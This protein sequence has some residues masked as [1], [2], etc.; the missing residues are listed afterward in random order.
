MSQRAESTQRFLAEVGSELA[1]CPQVL[2]EFSIRLR[3]QSIEQSGRLT[4]WL[5]GNTPAD[6]A[7]MNRLLTGLAAPVQVQRAQLNAEGPLRQGISIAVEPEG[8]E[9]RLYLHGRQADT[10]AD[11]YE[12]WRWR[13]GSDPLRTQYS[14]HY[15]PE[16]ATG[17]RPQ[18]LCIA[19][20]RAPLSTLLAEE[21][22]QQCSGFWL[23][24]DPNGQLEKLDLAF[25]WSPPAESL[26]GLHM[27]AAS[28]AIPMDERWR[29]VPVRHVSFPIGNSPPSV[30]L[31]ASAPHSGAWPQTESALQE[32]VCGSA[33]VSNRAIEQQLFGKLPDPATTPPQVQRNDHFYDGE[34]ATWRQIL[35]PELHYHFGIFDDPAQP[36]DSS[37]MD[38][39]LRRA[40]IELYPFLPAGQRIY[41]VGCGWGGPLAMWSRDLRCPS[42]GI[43]NSRTQFRYAAARGL[44]VRWG[45]A[46]QTLPPGRFACAVLLESLS[47]IRNKERLL[48]VLRLFS[49]RLVMRVNCQDAAPPGSA[50]GGSMQM[51]S[52]T[53]LRQ[54]L[55]ASGWR[56]RHFVDRRLETLPSIAVWQRQVEQ[57][58]IER[59][60]QDPHLAALRTWTARV[61]RFPMEWARNNPLIEVMAD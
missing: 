45:D 48:R 30:T 28:L 9:L 34:I 31:Y 47:H 32:R 40:V 60:L 42:L 26:L 23:R 20:L 37:Q 13:T 14:F 16:T 18:E 24:E 8:I 5:C 2:L 59:D 54:L 36:A 22:L 38:E 10:G 44:P 3:P 49:D 46:E 12:A 21:R 1:T 58:P 19:A 56:V 51:I 39:A 25:P 57:I 53:H 50:F 35:G 29:H 6:F 7:P 52:S 43:T 61:L 11:T 17:L 55:D 41:D 27:V 4:C 15:F 33:R